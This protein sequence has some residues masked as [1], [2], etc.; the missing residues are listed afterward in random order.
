M[1]LPIFDFISVCVI[2]KRSFTPKKFILL[3]IRLLAEN[4]RLFC[5]SL[6]HTILASG[7]KISLS[8]IH[9]AK[10]WLLPLPRPPFA[11]LY[12]AFFKSG[13]KIRGV[14][15]TK[16]AVIRPFRLLLRV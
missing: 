13:L 4:L 11:P 3:S 15:I 12:L 7:S 16:S 14:F 5:I 9:S 1:P 2:S 6:M 8:T 10:K